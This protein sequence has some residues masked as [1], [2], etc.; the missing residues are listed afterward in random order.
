MTRQLGENDVLAPEIYGPPACTLEPSEAGR[1]CAVEVVQPRHRERVTRRF[2][3]RLEAQTE[4]PSCVGSGTQQSARAV[5][6]EIARSVSRTADLALRTTAPAITCQSTTSRIGQ[7]EAERARRL[8][9]QDGRI[10]GAQPSYPGCVEAFTSLQRSAF[11]I[12]VNSIHAS[13]S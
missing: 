7:N 3:V 6:A 11:C 1:S 8:S 12:Q 10:S 5:S 4:A 9:L 2:S 13:A